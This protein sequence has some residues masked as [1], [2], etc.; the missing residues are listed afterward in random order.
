MNNLNR[1]AN[2]LRQHSSLTSKMT[3]TC[4]YKFKW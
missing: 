4:S 2:T 1:Q 3:L